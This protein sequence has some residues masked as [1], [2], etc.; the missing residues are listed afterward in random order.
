MGS[1]G[2]RA[3]IGGVSIFRVWLCPPDYK[4]PENINPVNYWNN[5]TLEK[6]E[7]NRQEIIKG[8]VK[9]DD[10]NWEGCLLSRLGFN[11]EDLLPRYGRQYNRFSPDT[12]NNP[13]PN[14]LQ[15]HHRTVA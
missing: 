1:Q 3:E 14:I 12:Y 7:E 10:D 8:C 15:N 9:A 6:T 11:V 13:N 5:S 4:T 2:I